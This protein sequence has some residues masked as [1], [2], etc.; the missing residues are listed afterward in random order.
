MI[1]FI[2]GTVFGG[3]VGVFTACMCAAAGQE[4]RRM[5]NIDDESVRLKNKEMDI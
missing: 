5:H 3:T 2:L 1:G 4:D